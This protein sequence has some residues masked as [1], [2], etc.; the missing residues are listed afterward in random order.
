LIHLIQALEIVH[1]SDGSMTLISSTQFMFVNRFLIC[2]NLVT[3]SGKYFMNCL[4]R[5]QRYALKSSAIY[6]SFS[7]FDRSSKSARTLKESNCQ[8]PRQL[9]RLSIFVLKGFYF[10]LHIEDSNRFFLQGKVQPI[11]GAENISQVFQ[12]GSP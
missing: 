2:A 9:L 12:L 10:V 3:G 7:S 4:W 8:W 1:L 6:T 5:P 11:Q